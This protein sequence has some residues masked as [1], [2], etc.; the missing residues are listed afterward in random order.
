MQ[1][2]IVTIISAKYSDISLI[3]WKRLLL[4]SPILKAFAETSLCTGTDPEVYQGGYIAG[5]GF[6]RGILY[7]KIMCEPCTLSMLLRVWGHAPQICSPET[8]SGSSFDGNLWVSGKVRHRQDVDVNSD[9]DTNSDLVTIVH[10]MPII[11]AVCKQ[12]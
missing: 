10:C 6:K 8:E 11:T 12:D 4:M 2:C 5:L 7:W 1:A 9:A 3:D